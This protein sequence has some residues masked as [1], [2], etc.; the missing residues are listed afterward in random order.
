MSSWPRT[1]RPA[2]TEKSPLSDLLYHLHGKLTRQRG[3]ARFRIDTTTGTATPLVDD[4]LVEITGPTGTAT[5][6]L[7]LSDT[8]MIPMDVD[9]DD[10]EATV[11]V[12]L[13]WPDGSTQAAIETSAR[14]LGEGE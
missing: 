11:Y 4:L 8:P 9:A 12:Q 7:K 13:R 2:R 3:E 1:C 10:V 14:E 5:L 6:N